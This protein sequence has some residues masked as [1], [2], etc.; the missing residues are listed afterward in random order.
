MTAHV[1]VLIA[2]CMTLIG[3]AAALWLGL[4]GRRRAEAERS[5]ERAAQR[6]A[7]DRRTRSRFLL[8]ALLFVLFNAVTV[9]FFAWAPVFRVLGW[10]GVGAMVMFATPIFVGLAYQ[11]RMRALE[12]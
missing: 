6:V 11:W 8:P 5:N 4:R 1:G 2:L 9:I 12:W 3:M 10:S 7:V